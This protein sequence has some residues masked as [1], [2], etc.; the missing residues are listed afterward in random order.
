[1]LFLTLCYGVS[2]YSRVGNILSMV[3]LNLHNNTQQVELKDIQVQITVT[4]EDEAAPQSEVLPPTTK[5]E[6]VKSKSQSA[7]K[8]KVSTVDDLKQ[9]I[10]MVIYIHNFFFTYL[11]S[12]SWSLRPL[13]S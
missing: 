9:E 2:I 10:Q 5:N 12:F 3:Y 13:S 8:D 7:K 1:M 11:L 4:A 6:E